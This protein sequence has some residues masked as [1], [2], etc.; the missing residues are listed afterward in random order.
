MEIWKTIPGYKGH[1]EVS[2]YGRVRTL[3][4]GMNP[5]YSTNNKPRVLK[6][7]LK[8]S[9]YLALDLCIDNVK[10]TTTV[11]RLV[12]KAFLD[13]KDGKYTVNHK[14]GNKTDNRVINLEW[15]TSSE[16]TQHRFKVLNQPGP[17]RKQ[18]ICVET[19]QVFASST[20]AAEWLSK[21]YNRTKQVYSVARRIRAACGGSTKTAYGY[22]WKDIV[23]V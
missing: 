19:K 18:I 8:R 22:H 2:S 9:G 11:H 15:A 23:N 13:N 16:N 14:N 17:N 7:A 21:N 5:K 1:Y 12:A 3:K 10:K 20:Q 6:Q 4:N